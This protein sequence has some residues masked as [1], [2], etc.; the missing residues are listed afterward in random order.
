VI[1]TKRQRYLA[2]AT[3]A[4]VVIF[5]LDRFMVG[6][7][8]AQK[9]QLDVSIAEQ[10]QRLAAAQ[11]TFTTS[12]RVSGQWNAMLA[13]GL[14]TDI[15]E[16]E[17]QIL[18]AIREWAQ[19]AGMALSSVKPER[20]EREKDFQKITL[21]ATGTGTMQQVSRFLWQLQASPIPVRITDLQI[22]A[23]KEGID[24]LSIQLGIAT[25]CFAPEPPKVVA[26]V[27]REV[28]R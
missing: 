24:D 20:I 14:K 6:P 21:R 13:G 27:S 8:M 1:V 3:V 23:R 4:V 10:Q 7:L 25:I 17:S 16:A 26:A 28:T 12:R 18:H 19:G 15:S 11:R 5:G 9:E 2:L 22:N